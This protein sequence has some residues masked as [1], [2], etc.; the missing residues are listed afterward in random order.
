MQSYQI[1]GPS[2]ANQLLSYMS[3]FIVTE[4]SWELRLLMT[5]LEKEDPD[6]NIDV[7]MLSDAT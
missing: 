2:W 7:S 4:N 6:L 5:D 1:P 3:F